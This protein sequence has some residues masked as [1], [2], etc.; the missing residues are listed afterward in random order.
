MNT[1]GT[2]QSSNPIPIVPKT[3][4]ICKTSIIVKK[5]V[6][7]KKELA[8]VLPFIVFIAEL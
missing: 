5:I 3:A 7:V 8:L 2:T 6:A 1:I 4:I